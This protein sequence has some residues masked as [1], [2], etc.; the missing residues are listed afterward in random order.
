MQSP[1]HIWCISTPKREDNQG[2]FWNRRYLI[3]P[4]AHN[5]LEDRETE[6]T[7]FGLLKVG[8]FNLEAWINPG[9]AV[10]LCQRTKR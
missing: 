7:P 5:P 8:H 6:M 3:D 9:Y 4:L 10:L 2:Y 1:P